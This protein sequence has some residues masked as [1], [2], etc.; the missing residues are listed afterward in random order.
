MKKI[1]LTLFFLIMCVNAY[2]QNDKYGNPIF[3]SISI[4]GID[5]ENKK[6]ISNYYTIRNNI[7]N[8]ESSVF[9]GKNPN[10]EE[11]M[12]FSTLLPAYYFI[13]V[14]NQNVEGMA[15]LLPNENNSGVYSYNVMI[16]SKD[17][18][19]IVPS[20]LKGDIMEHRAKEMLS[21]KNKETNIKDENLIYNQEKLKII[22]YK[23]VLDEVKNVVFDKIVNFSIE[24]YIERESEE[25]GTLDMKKMIKEKYPDEQFFLVGDYAYN[26]KDFAIF[27]WGA[28]VKYNGLED[29]EKAKTLW[30]KINGRNL[31][32][33]E[34]I[35]LK[36]GL[37]N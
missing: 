30:Q 24:N 1:L 36:R 4:E 26:E 12:R 37:E 8:K 16:P 32:D 21:I 35:I 9:V 33:N 20:S 6:I 27:L 2:S 3:N 28:A 11:Y 29:F 5:Y 31:T 19:F 18:S 13:I 23:D 14:D 17:M 10:I 22:E 25:G 34:E 7:D 15:M